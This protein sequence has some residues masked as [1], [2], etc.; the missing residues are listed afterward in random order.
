MSQDDDDDDESEVTGNADKA[1]EDM[2]KLTT[3]F[4][5]MEDLMKDFRGVYKETH[6][7]I[8][9]EKALKEKYCS[10]KYN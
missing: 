3:K 6:A 4:K 1:D 9:K 2:Q 7:S 5:E 8:R 10:T